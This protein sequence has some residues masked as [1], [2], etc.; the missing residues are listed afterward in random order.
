LSELLGVMA[1]SRSLPSP[2][3][4]AWGGPSRGPFAL[5]FAGAPVPAAL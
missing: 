1:A 4:A 3:L 5:E 2:L